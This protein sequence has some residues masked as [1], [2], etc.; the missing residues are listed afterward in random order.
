MCH[1]F[2]SAIQH[3]D[4]MRPRSAAL[5]SLRWRTTRR[6]VPMAP[7]RARRRQQPVIGSAHV[8]DLGQGS[9]HIRLAFEEH[10]LARALIGHFGGVLVNEREHEAAFDADTDDK[11]ALGPHGAGV[12]L[13]SVAAITT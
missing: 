4:N 7:P 5:P 10:R 3:A 13:Q 12:R 2:T 8:L 11:D 1:L 6:G 9:E